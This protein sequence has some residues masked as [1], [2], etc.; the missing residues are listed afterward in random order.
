MILHQESAA[1]FFLQVLNLSSH[2]KLTSAIL[3]E[4]L[5]T[6]MKSQERPGVRDIAGRIEEV[7]SS[8]NIVL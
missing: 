6:A 1:V 2:E 8:V 7:H 5:G 3:P 4:R